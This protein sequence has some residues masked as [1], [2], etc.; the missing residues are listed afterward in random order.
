MRRA[1]TLEQLGRFWT[2]VRP[3]LAARVPAQPVTA[4]V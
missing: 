3:A 1:E 2:D 4:G